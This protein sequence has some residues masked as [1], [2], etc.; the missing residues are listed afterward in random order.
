M[1]PIQISPI[2]VAFLGSSLFLGYQGVKWA[3]KGFS[4]VS[5]IP[6][7]KETFFERVER[8]IE[9]VFQGNFSI[10]TFVF[11]KKSNIEKWVDVAR[12]ITYFTTSFFSICLS[13]TLFYLS[14]NRVDQGEYSAA[15]CIQQLDV[16]T[17]R[18][19][20]VNDFALY[21]QKSI[22]DFDLASWQK[23][24][25]LNYCFEDSYFARIHRKMLPCDEEWSSWTFRYLDEDYHLTRALEKEIQ[26]FTQT[27]QKAEKVCHNHLLSF[28]LEVNDQCQALSPYVLI[29]PSKLCKVVH[30]AKDSFTKNCLKACDLYESQ[31]SILKDSLDLKAPQTRGVSFHCDEVNLLE[32]PPMEKIFPLIPKPLKPSSNL[33]KVLNNHPK[34]YAQYGFGSLPFS[35]TL[36]RLKA[37]AKLE[38]ELDSMVSQESLPEELNQFFV[39]RQKVIA[40]LEEKRDYHNLFESI[41]NKMPIESYNA[42]LSLTLNQVR[43]L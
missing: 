1:N 6:F 5:E 30:W 42:M 35:K 24:A 17:N 7:G 11:G 18:H 33:L 23:A 25:H 34:A 13:S 26:S 10:Q 22:C 12:A 43:D 31:S 37:K 32:N 39:F 38:L 19:K 29:D 8:A 20:L 27:Q 9:E 16:L 40:L 14:K 3:A 41:R 2:P 4:K 36:D 15:P 21:W 28:E